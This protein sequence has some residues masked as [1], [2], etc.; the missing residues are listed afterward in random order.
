MK[1]YFE[2]KDILGNIY[3]SD[4]GEMTITKDDFS[5]KIEPLKNI[6]ELN[7]LSIVVDG[8]ECIFNPDNIIYFKTVCQE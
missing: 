7:Y 1:Y 5:K 2:V 4:Q 8:S 6:K 3:K